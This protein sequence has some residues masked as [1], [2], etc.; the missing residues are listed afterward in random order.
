VTQQPSSGL[1]HLFVEV[2]NHA[3]LDAN[4]RQNCSTWVISL[5]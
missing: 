1:G 2:P 4:T 5:A 3:Q